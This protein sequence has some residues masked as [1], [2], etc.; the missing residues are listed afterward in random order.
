[1]VA[2]RTY[3]YYNARV[4]SKTVLQLQAQACNAP[5]LTLEHFDTATLLT[6][7]YILHQQVKALF[8]SKKTIEYRLVKYFTLAIKHFI[9]A[10]TTFYTGI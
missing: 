9:L 8:T 3:K 10:S 5:T 4:N 2:A 7:R 6:L 1:M